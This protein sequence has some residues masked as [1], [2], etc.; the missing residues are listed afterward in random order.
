MLRR[1][2]DAAYDDWANGG[3]VYVQNKKGKF[4]VPGYPTKLGKPSR[5]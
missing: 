4:A 3:C 1:C 5:L 2:W